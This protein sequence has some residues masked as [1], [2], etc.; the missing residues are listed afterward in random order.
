MEV[1]GQDRGEGLGRKQEPRVYL[2]AM[3]IASVLLLLSSLYSAEASVFRKARESVLDAASPILALFAGPIAFVQGVVGDISEYWNAIEQNRA[4]RAEIADLRQW[5]DEAIALRRTIAQYER[6]G[7]FE[8]PPDARPVNGFVISDSNDA[9]SRSMVVNVGAGKGIAR[10]QAVINDGGLVGQVVE[11]GRSASRIL[12][13]TDVQSR[14]PVFVEEA[15]LEGIL[16]G[17]SNGRPAISFTQSS[18]PVAFSNGQRV[19]TS[20]AGGVVPRGLPVGRISNEKDGAAVVDLYA[21]YARTRLVRIINYE[22]PRVD[23]A[24]IETP[25]PL[26]SAARPSTALP[27]APPSPPPAEQTD[28][29]PRQIADDEAAAAAVPANEGD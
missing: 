11:T 7:G 12:L 9:Y 26:G 13:L 23:P 24:P 15:G 6:L 29:E 3:F 4:L 28:D 2:V 20:G 1:L 21:D 17:R 18:E 10:G 8:A 22:F 14:V 5:E 27:T 19:V 25:E 16:T